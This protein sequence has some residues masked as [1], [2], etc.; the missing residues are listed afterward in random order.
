MNRKNFIKSILALIPATVCT[1]KLFN[2]IKESCTFSDLKGVGHI[3]SD[4]IYI[5][6]KTSSSPR[7]KLVVHNLPQGALAIIE[8]N[9]REMTYVMEN[10]SGEVIQVTTGKR[11]LS[12]TFEI[13]CLP[14]MDARKYFTKY[15]LLTPKARLNAIINRKDP[16]VPQ[17]DDYLD[18]ENKRLIKIF[19]ELG[20]YEVHK[21]IR[22]DRTYL[23]ADDPLRKKCG[24][25]GYEE[26]GFIGIKKS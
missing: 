9:P 16:F 12:R 10:R 5:S 26:V 18:K 6:S 22:Q 21:F 7:C 8:R 4:S 25:V 15:K 24:L 14:E 3:W 23:L 17:V 11:A 1:S 20:C 13:A 2:K 19:E